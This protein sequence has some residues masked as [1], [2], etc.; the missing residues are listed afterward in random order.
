MFIIAFQLLQLKV[1][2]F[3]MSLNEFLIIQLVILLP[4]IV[5]VVIS[6]PAATLHCTGGR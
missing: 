6:C 2:L 3:I 5:N 1:F 4:S